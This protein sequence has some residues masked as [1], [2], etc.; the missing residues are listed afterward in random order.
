VLGSVDLELSYWVSNQRFDYHRNL[1]SKTQIQDLES[2]GFPWKNKK[3]SESEW[4]KHFDA[5]VRYKQLIAP[6]EPPEEPIGT[7]LF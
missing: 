4:E 2:I 5:F 7:I 3:M 1:L 6:P